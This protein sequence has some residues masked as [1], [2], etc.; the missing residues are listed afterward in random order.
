VENTQEDLQLAGEVGISIHTY[1]IVVG[2]KNKYSV[3]NKIYALNLETLQWIVYFEMPINICAHGSVIV[4]H[5]IYIFGGTNGTEFF[6]FLFIFNVKTKK[7]FRANLK[8]EEVTS[9]KLFGRIAVSMLYDSQISKI[10]VFG[11][12]G[13]ED[14]SQ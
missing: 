7:M 9:L 1:L 12:C 8:K 11:G 3:T 2:G 5:L 13:F 6:D 14:D 4:N 10:L